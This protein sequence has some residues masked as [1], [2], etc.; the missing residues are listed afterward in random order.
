M[1]NVIDQKILERDPSSRGG[2]AYRRTD[3]ARMAPVK[4]IKFS[5]GNALPEVQKYEH[6]RIK[7]KALL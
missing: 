1:S 7:I 5:Q 6:F 2:G 4:K 3:R